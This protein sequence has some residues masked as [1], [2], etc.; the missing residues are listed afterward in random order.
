METRTLINGTCPEC[1]GPLTEVQEDHIVQYEC[2]VGHVYSPRALLDGHSEA[3]ERTLWAAVVALEETK[4]IVGAVRSHLPPERTQRLE[5][6]VL[7]K[8]EQAESIRRILEQ[9]E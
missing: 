7:R 3:Q 1:R 2:L 4:N 5:A 6:Q 8:Q 9:L